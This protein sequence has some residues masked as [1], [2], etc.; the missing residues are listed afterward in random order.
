MR[1]HNRLRTSVCGG[2]KQPG[3]LI[4][5]LRFHIYLGVQFPLLYI[6]SKSIKCILNIDNNFFD[7][8]IPNNNIHINL[9][10]KHFINIR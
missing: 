6:N 4:I 3:Q 2:Y 7:K 5:N 1:T 8:Y 9:F 10:V